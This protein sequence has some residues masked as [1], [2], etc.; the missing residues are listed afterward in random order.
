MS[1]IRWPVMCISASATG[2]PTL[3]VAACITQN[4]TALAPRLTKAHADVLPVLGA[5]FVCVDEELVLEANHG[6]A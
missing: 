4:G 5:L 3:G 6:G 1:D 2:S